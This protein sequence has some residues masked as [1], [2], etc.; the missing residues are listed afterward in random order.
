MIEILIT[1]VIL[2]VG[3]LGVAALQATSL[4]NNH[5]AYHRTQ[6]THLA[7]NLA[8]RMRANLDLKASYVTN[9]P[10]TASLQPTCLTTAGCTPANL[11]QHD[12]KE[13]HNKLI[14]DLPSVSA[15]IT[16]DT[17]TFTITINWDDNRDG[18]V[19]ANDPNFAVSFEL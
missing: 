19:D 14:N 16:E 5:S 6:A 18:N 12:L 15:T 13:W 7:Y 10:S 11:A 9:D 1:I 17:G 8:D 4:K 3:L 2:S